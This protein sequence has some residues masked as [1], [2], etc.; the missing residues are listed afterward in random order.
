MHIQHN[1]KISK[2]SPQENS[3]KIFQL[4]LNRVSGEQH[5]QKLPS[6]KKF[7][8]KKLNNS[9]M[10]PFKEGPNKSSIDFLQQ[11][12]LMLMDRVMD[13]GQTSNL[14]VC[15]NLCCQWLLWRKHKQNKLNIIIC[16]YVNIFVNLENLHCTSKKRKVL[17]N[18]VC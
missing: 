2:E 4:N 18:N 6:K 11:F 10:G 13:N 12:Q 15:D 3:C 14:L 17:L 8:E 5:F 7:C 9:D 1:L 16:I